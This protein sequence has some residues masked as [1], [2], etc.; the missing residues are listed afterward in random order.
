MKFNRSKA[1]ELFA[2]LVLRRGAPCTVKEIAAVIFED[3]CYDKKQKD[4]MQQIIFT[5]IHNLTECNAGKAIIKGFNNLCI[6][7]ACVDCD[8]YRI[9]SAADSSISEY[10]G[11]FMLQ[12]SWA[13]EMTGY[14][15]RLAEKS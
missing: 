11:E 8:F 2:Y 15:D 1:L 7:P 6:D 5:M 13:E 10:T 3:A 14:L 12:Y 4:Y 9:D